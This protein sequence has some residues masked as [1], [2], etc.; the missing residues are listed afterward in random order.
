TLILPNDRFL[1]SDPTIGAIFGQF[2]SVISNG[3]NVRIQGLAIVG[4]G[5]G[6]SVTVSNATLTSVNSLIV[7]QTGHATGT[8]NISNGATVTNP[9]VSVGK[10]ASTSGTVNVSGVG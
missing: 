10:D 5:S 8:L 1:N 9:G 7:G 4:I 6:S 2:N 3:Q